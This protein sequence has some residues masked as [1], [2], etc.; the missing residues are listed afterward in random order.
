MVEFLKKIKHKLLTL[1]SIDFSERLPEE[2]PERPKIRCNKILG[3]KKGG[4]HAT[5]CL[6]MPL[7]SFKKHAPGG[8][9]EIKIHHGRELIN[10]GDWL[11]LK[12]YDPDVNLY[13]GRTITGKIT[14]FEPT[15]VGWTAYFDSDTVYSNEDMICAP[16]PQPERAQKI[17]IIKT[18][19]EYYKASADGIKKF[20][21]RKNDRDYRPGDILVLKEWET[22]TGYSGRGSRAEIT[23][24]ITESEYLAPGYAA[25]GIEIIEDLP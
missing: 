9:S 19:P 5:H 7:E 15:Y 13:T 22:A 3:T 11:T 14:N 12:E 24:I 6:A 10:P 8:T 1:H 21:L 23:Y 2:I 25:L 20:E 16:E 18:L 17:H 4:N